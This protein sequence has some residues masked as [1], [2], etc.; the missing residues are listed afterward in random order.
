MVYGIKQIFNQFLI[1]N[2]VCVCVCVKV[3]GLIFLGKFLQCFV[4]H[5]VCSLCLRIK[6][7]C[8]R[9]S[10]NDTSNQMYRNPRKNITERTEILQVL[11]S[12]VV[13]RIKLI[14]LFSGESFILH[15]GY[16]ELCYS[17]VIQ[18]YR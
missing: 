16:N 3:H 4:E 12:C 18:L 6:T 2:F 7:G 9:I 1:P 15:T 10:G 17:P 13:I 11:P 14:L 8:D 5:S